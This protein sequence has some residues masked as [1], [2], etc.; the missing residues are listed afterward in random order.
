VKRSATIS[1]LS[2]LALSASV[3]GSPAS[4]TSVSRKA[5]VALARKA[6]IVKSDF[7]KGWT[8]SASGGGPST[9]AEESQAVSCLGLPKS[10]AKYNPPE[11]D[12]PSFNDN[13]L[14][15][16]VEDSVDVFPNAKIA[17]QQY[18]VYASP[19]SVGC[20]QRV[21]RSAAMK[22]LL[23][24][25]VGKGAVVGNTVMISLPAPVTT[26]ES[27]AL[28]AEIPLTY[29]GIHIVIDTVIVLIM[30]KSKTEGAQLTLGNPATS[31]FPSTLTKHLESLTVQRLG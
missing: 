7:P 15:L 27:A 21:F 23:A 9:N 29:K 22:S 25:G 2:V 8:T 30:S 10:V 24:S 20:F 17:A 14:G 16:T 26:N 11:A 1:L 31:P 19:R 28:E 5:D 13:G 12:S 18:N 6:L 4:A 3:L